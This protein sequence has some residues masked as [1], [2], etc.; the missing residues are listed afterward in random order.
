MSTLGLK[1]KLHSLIDTINDSDKIKAM[2]TLL[3]VNDS[4]DDWYDDISDNQKASIKK[5]LN[6]IKNGRVKNHKEASA[7]IDKFIS[8]NYA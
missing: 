7:E 1:N 5:G 6:D 3:N 2:L 4:T 8:E